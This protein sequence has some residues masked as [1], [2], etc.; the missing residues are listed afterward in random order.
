[1]KSE[2]FSESMLTEVC[3]HLRLPAVAREAPRLA[4]EASRQQIDFISFLGELLQIENEERMLRRAQRRLKEAGFPIVKT[5]A[6]FDFS[7][8]PHL[9][10][11]FLR[12]LLLGSYITEAEPIIFMGEPGTGKTHL[13]TAFGV[14]AT[15]EGLSVKFVTAAQLIN[16]LREAQDSRELSRVLA[17]Y[18][19]VEVL[20]LDELGYLPL[21]HSDAEFLFQALSERHERKTLILTTNLPFSEWTSVFPDTRL[22]RA[23][24]DRLTHRAH[25]IETGTESIRLKDALAKSSKGKTS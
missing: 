21:S 17:R 9:P 1:M 6:Q 14:A 25:I 3:R 8:S 13:A 18:N 19:R 24:I 2:S 11:S 22:C 15:Q 20:I 4:R 5:M 7:R 16:Q 10:E 12:S 23:M